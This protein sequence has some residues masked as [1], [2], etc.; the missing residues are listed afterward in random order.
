MNIK[1]IGNDIFRFRIWNLLGPI[2]GHLTIWW[3]KASGKYVIG[4]HGGFGSLTWYPKTKP[5]IT[6]PTAEQ[7]EFLEP[8]VE[9]ELHLAYFY[10]G[11]KRL[12]YG[13]FLIDSVQKREDDGEYFGVRGRTIFQA[14]SS[15]EREPEEKALDEQATILL[16][17]NSKEGKAA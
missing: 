4:K 13:K 6:F 2:D 15:V 11:D 1:D 8:I 16:L 10:D 5:D 9:E 14:D 12:N 3:H 17:N 7:A